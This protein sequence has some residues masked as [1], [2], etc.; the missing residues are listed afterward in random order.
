MTFLDKLHFPAL[1]ANAYEAA[2]IFMEPM[3][4]SGEFFAV[5]GVATRQGE[6]SVTS[7]IRRETIDCLYG[8]KAPQFIG[9]VEIVI[10]SI[11]RHLDASLPLSSWDAP[12]DGVKLGEIRT[13][14]ADNANHAVANIATLHAS[15]SRLPAMN[16]DEDDESATPPT[17]NTMRAWVDQIQ[18]HVLASNALAANWFNHKI[19]IAQGDKALFH[20][21]HGSRAANIGLMTP[22]SFGSRANDAKVKLWNLEHLSSEYS[23]KKMIIGI[24]RDDA[25]DMADSKVRDKLHGKISALQEEAA[26]GDV[27]LFQ[28]FSAQEAAN[29]LLVA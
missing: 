2:P 7:L 3:R 4:G 19:E 23:D 11:N 21:V 24:P 28:V 14:R 5:C 16:S 1:P 29:I 26:K 13:V 25:P 8:S 20:F 17:E 10:K 18:G 27:T 6:R 15:L 22:V 12:I 9:I